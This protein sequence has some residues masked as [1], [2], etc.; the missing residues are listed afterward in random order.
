M[1]DHIYGRGHLSIDLKWRH[2]EMKGIFFLPKMQQLS[3]LEIS[4]FLCGIIRITLTT[5]LCKTGRVPIRTY[6]CAYS[7]TEMNSQKQDNFINL[8]NKFRLS[9]TCHLPET[10]KRNICQCQ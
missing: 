5:C 6:L 8:R 9:E 10:R 2:A 4:S 1:D 3:L 7:I